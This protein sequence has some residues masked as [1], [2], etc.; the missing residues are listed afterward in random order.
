MMDLNLVAS[1]GVAQR[2]A[3]SAVASSLPRGSQRLPTSG[4]RGGKLLL[5]TCVGVSRTTPADCSGLASYTLFRTDVKRRRRRE[6]VTTKT[7][8]KA[9]AA[10]AMRGL[11]R[12]AAASGRAAML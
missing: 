3:R 9:I 6:L 11:S 1:R 7:E 10:A 4:P 12:P 5:M 2:P 8:L